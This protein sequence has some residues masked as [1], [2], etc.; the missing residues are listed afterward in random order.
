MEW[1][2]THPEKERVEFL[3]QVNTKYLVRNESCYT[4][5]KSTLANV[6]AV[7]DKSNSNSASVGQDYCLFNAIGKCSRKCKYRHACAL[8]HGTKKDCP[9]LGGNWLD[10]HLRGLSVPKKIINDRRDANTHGSFRRRSGSPRREASS[11]RQHQRDSN[12]ATERPP[13][14][15][16]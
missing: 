4:D 11:P 7:P 6:A 14:K 10:Y 15:S 9:I 1:A 8:C 3:A 13:T 5:A 12:N 16:G 2:R